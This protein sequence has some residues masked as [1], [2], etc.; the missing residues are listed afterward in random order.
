[1]PESY[2][3]TTYKKNWQSFARMLIIKQKALRL[4]AIVILLI[5]V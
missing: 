5:A 2:V 4:K 3:Y 1:M